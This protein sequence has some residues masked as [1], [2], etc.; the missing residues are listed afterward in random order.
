M[1]EDNKGTALSNVIRIDDDRV[2]E[3]LDKVVR[4]TVEETSTEL[5]PVVRVKNGLRER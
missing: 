1:E 5:A 3:H 2:K 4:G